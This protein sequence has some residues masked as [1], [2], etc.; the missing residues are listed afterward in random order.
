MKEGAEMAEVFTTNP[1]L[2]RLH[3][4]RDAAERSMYRALKEIQRLRKP[5]KRAAEEDTAE[6]ADAGPALELGSFLRSP[7]ARDQETGEGEAASAADPRTP[8]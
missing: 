2:A 6:G 8:K 7:N 1:V 5:E 4:R 3:R